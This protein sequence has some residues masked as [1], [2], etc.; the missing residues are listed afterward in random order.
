M[1]LLTRYCRLDLFRRS[2]RRYESSEYISLSRGLL[3]LALTP[4]GIVPF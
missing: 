2:A 3:G 1:G 4:Y